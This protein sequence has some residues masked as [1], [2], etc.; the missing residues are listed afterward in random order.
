MT[1]VVCFR[2]EDAVAFDEETGVFTFVTGL[3]KINVYKTTLVS[4]E[5]PVSQRTIEAQ[6]SQFLYSEGFLVGPI[7]RSVAAREIVRGATNSIVEISATLPLASQYFEVEIVDANTIRVST[8][9]D[10]LATP[11]LHGLFV[12]GTCIADEWATLMGEPITLAIASVSLPPPQQLQLQ[13]TC[14]NLTYETE[15]EFLVTTPTATLLDGTVGFLYTPPIQTPTQ[16]AALLQ[17]IFGQYNTVNGYD[18]T[19]DAPTMR[20]TVAGRG[21][22]EEGTILQLTGGMASGLMA[23]LGFACDLECAAAGDER[24]GVGW[25][26]AAQQT[27][28]GCWPCDRPT[29]AARTDIATAACRDRGIE[30]AL[31]A[32]LSLPDQGF[33]EDRALPPGA[34]PPI[35]VLRRECDRYKTLA[36]ESDMWTPCGLVRVNP[37]WYTPVVRP[38]GV[39]EPL[40]SELE[41][42]M[43]PFRFSPPAANQ[44]LSGTTTAIHFIVLETPWGV[45]LRA[46]IDMGHYTPHVLAETIE[47]NVKLAAAN[48]GTPWTTL[49]VTFHEDSNQFIIADV[50]QQPFGLRFD[51]V[52][53]FDPRRIGFEARRYFG[54]FAYAGA[55]MVL[56]RRSS[57]GQESPCPVVLRLSTVPDALLPGVLQTLAGGTDGVYNVALTTLSGAGVGGTAIVTV[58]GTGTV[59]E[60]ITV[61]EPGT[62]YSMTESILIAAG[63]LG[64]GSNQVTINAPYDAFVRTEEPCCQTDPLL[65]TEANALLSSITNTLL[66][67]TVGTYSNVPLLGGSP[68]IQALVEVEVT[69]GPILQ[70]ITV[71]TAGAGYAVGDLLSIASGSLGV[72]STELTIR[73]SAHDFARIPNPYASCFGWPLNW[74]MVTDGGATRRYNFVGTPPRTVHVRCINCTGDPPVASSPGCDENAPDSPPTFAMN[75]Q[76]AL[77]LPNNIPGTTYAPF[78]LPYQQGDVVILSNIPSGIRY[79]AIVLEDAGR[80]ALDSGGVPI[81]RLSLYVPGVMQSDIGC[82]WEWTVQAAPSY[83]PFSMAIPPTDASCTDL[84][85]IPTRVLGLS[86]GATLWQVDTDN[87]IVAPNLMDLEHVD[88]ILMDLG[89]DFLRK[90]DTFQLAGRKGN[91]TSFAKLVLYPQYQ[92]HGLLPRDLLTT[93]MDS[94][95]R[96][97]VRFQNP[98]GTP[99]RLNGR[100]FSFSLQ[101]VCPAG[102]M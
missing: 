33:R 95:V 38:S 47:D 96:F 75:L 46:P 98:D 41:L 18:V 35:T 51:D 97:N 62:G 78:A 91:T 24:G 32:Q 61:V 26:G 12:N 67:G 21:Y 54:S 90:T 36:C 30:R 4:L 3:E 84:S 50:A 10:D 44:Q 69:A 71:T 5:F 93:S 85:P 49:S 40:N 34:G 31:L 99:Y 94:P 68:T 60:A 19:F 56:P 63:L 6:S 59:V 45:V 79:N 92:V 77:P 39:A 57:R 11:A 37:G 87:T 48:S 1:W 2:R 17:W 15:T 7:G 73:L 74:Y 53:M 88:Y 72:G 55:Q 101:F 8:M 70:K 22:V 100:S 76:T 83:S 66:V 82:D 43:A 27:V 89:W 64:G 16:G 65:S 20:T 29:L 80:S 13:L 23:W 9:E 28:G 52:Y 14:A 102:A 25:L 42:R 86:E 81:K 58:S